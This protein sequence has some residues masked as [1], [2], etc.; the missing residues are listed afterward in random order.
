MRCVKY[1]K[2]PGKEKEEMRR[3]DGNGNIELQEAKNSTLKE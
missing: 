2:H 1:T 3:Q